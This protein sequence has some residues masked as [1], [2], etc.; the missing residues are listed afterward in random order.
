MSS[1]CGGFFGICSYVLDDP[2][3]PVPDSFKR[4]DLGFGMYT[5]NSKSWQITDSV[6]SNI[7]E[8]YNNIIR[9]AEKK[10]D[11]E[12]RITINP[13]EKIKLT[14]QELAGAEIRIMHMS[15]VFHGADMTD[16]ELSEIHPDEYPPEEFLDAIGVA[17]TDEQSTPAVA[18]SRI[19]E[20]TIESDFMII[21]SDKDACILT[22]H[23]NGLTG[24]FD[25]H[26]TIWVNEL[27]Q[28]VEHE[29]SHVFANVLGLTD[30]EEDLL[31]SC[32]PDITHID[33]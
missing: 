24:S 27:G 9:C 11:A 2:P 22:E 16:E 3:A 23:A 19:L 5:D 20:G 31:E 8:Q 30:E 25:G 10:L 32:T 18:R 14:E 13:A 28:L 33:L 29:F 1:G 26:M 4:S 6:G 7:D 21:L 12:I 15:S 17:R